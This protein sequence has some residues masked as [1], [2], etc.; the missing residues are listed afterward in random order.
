LRISH[1]FL[2]VILLVVP[3]Q[4]ET[5]EDKQELPSFQTYWEVVSWY[6]KNYDMDGFQDTTVFPNSER[7][8]NPSNRR[9]PLSARWHSQSKC[10][11]R[12]TS[13]NGIS[14]TLSFLSKLPNSRRMIN[15]RAPG[16]HLAANLQVYIRENGNNWVWWWRAGILQIPTRRR[17][18]QI[19]QFYNRAVF[20]SEFGLQAIRSDVP[21]LN[22][23]VATL[24]KSNVSGLEKK[25]D[26]LALWLSTI[27][28]RQE[29]WR[30]CET[31]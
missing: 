22:L 26:M 21:L 1:L 27:S 24:S 30:R 11:Q 15:T 17:R 16:N 25:R 29:S 13:Y 20:L 31:I 14:N 5:S 4:T 28:C 8:L 6:S 7:N 23:D 9:I 19:R 12:G 10:I 3:I 18:P 2:L